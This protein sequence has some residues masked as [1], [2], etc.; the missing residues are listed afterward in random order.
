MYCVLPVFFLAVGGEFY[1]STVSCLVTISI[2]LSPPPP[3]PALFDAARIART[4]ESLVPQNWQ[5]VSTT[6]EHERTAN[7]L[8]PFYEK[9]VPREES[10]TSDGSAERGHAN[11]PQEEVAG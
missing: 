5:G 4:H 2:Y 9:A 10:I 11:A 7:A 3:P 1:E 6:V 8:L